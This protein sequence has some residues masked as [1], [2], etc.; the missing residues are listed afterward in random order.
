MKKIVSVCGFTFS[1]L[2][3]TYTT[4]Y[5]KNCLK[6]CNINV[7]LNINFFFER[8]LNINLIQYTGNMEIHIHYVTSFVLRGQSWKE[9]MGELIFYSKIKS[10]QCFQSLAAVLSHVESLENFKNKYKIKKEKVR[11]ETIHNKVQKKKNMRG[12]RQTR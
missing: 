12:D 5:D 9:V 8:V 7:V 1:S 10:F 11:N 6:C 2:T 4:N 3:T